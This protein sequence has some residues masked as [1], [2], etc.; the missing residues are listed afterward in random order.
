M[1]FIKIFPF[2]TLTAIFTLTNTA[3][4]ETKQPQTKQQIQK[5]PQSK[6]RQK[7]QSTKEPELAQFNN[8]VNIR[9][10]S[11]N[12]LV[13]NQGNK[14]V[15]LSYTLK[16]KSKKAIKSV[17]WLGAYLVNNEL[18]H[19]EDLPIKFETPLPANSKEIDITVSIPFNALKPQAQAA[20]NDPQANITGLVV[21]REIV[22]ANGKKI[23]VK[24]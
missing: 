2:I 4:A 21:A 14:L 20:F 15:S 17:H 6:K 3:Y 19:I 11:R 18:L 22:F 10:V 8:T 7:D 5:K 16:N 23:E 1:K 12:I 24:N 13:D 9:L